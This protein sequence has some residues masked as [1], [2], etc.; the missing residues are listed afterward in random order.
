MDNPN[1][2]Y[3]SAQI[4]GAVWPTES[5]ASEEAVR[6]HMKALRRKLAETGCDN[7]IKTVA[8]AGYV[9]EDPLR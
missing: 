6:V 2:Y 3:S 1:S 4:L 7:L 8:G 5:E 9:I